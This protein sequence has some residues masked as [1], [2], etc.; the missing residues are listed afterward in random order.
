MAYTYDALGRLL[1][2]DSGGST[3]FPQWGLRWWYDRYG[4]RDEQEQTY[5]NPPA[6]NP[7]IDAATNR[8]TDSAYAYDAN[9]NMLQD[10]ANTLV[11]DAENRLVSSTASGGGLAVTYTY[12]GSSLRV[13]RA[14]NGATVTMIFSGTKIVADYDNGAGPT[15]PA[16]EHFWS[17]GVL[18][19]PI[20]P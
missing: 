18:R 20:F 13:K 6:H 11:Y 17:A 15:T 1:T 14:Y 2:A 3:Q 12:D 5:G 9:G 4:N 8:F 19:I 10:G 7:T 16:R